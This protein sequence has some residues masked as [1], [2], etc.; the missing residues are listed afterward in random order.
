MTEIQNCLRIRGLMLAYIDKM[1]RLDIDTSNN[2]VWLLSSSETKPIDSCLSG[3]R[4]VQLF[5][6]IVCDKLLARDK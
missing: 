4:T 6:F 5:T 3:A 2:V 1:F